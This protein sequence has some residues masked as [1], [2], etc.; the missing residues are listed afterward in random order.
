MRYNQTDLPKMVPN[1]LAASCLRNLDIPLITIY[2]PI[3]SHYVAIMHLHMAGAVNS[4]TDQ[5]KA[6]T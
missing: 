4:V 6:L 1:S 3:K 5:Y 2:P